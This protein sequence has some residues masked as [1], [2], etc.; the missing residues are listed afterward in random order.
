MAKGKSKPRSGKW[1]TAFKAA[2]AL[3]GTAVIGY[4]AKKMFAPKPG[5]GAGVVVGGAGFVLATVLGLF[6]GTRKYVPLAL[7][8]SVGLGVLEGF[9][10]SIDKAS[11]WVADLL[12]G[13]GGG[14]TKTTASGGGAGSKSS[15]GQGGAGPS[16]QQSSGGQSIA[17][18][19]VNQTPKQAKPDKVS[20][21]LQ[22][23]ESLAN[24]GSN[25]AGALRG[26]GVPAGSVGIDDFSDIQGANGIDDFSSL[27]GAGNSMDDIDAIADAIA[28]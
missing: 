5:L 17:Y 16:S 20:Q 2:I 22:F 14:M 23:G 25:I 4:G 6:K 7:G 24:L 1:G 13:K 12:T 9:D 10:T 21:Y 27:T 28:R 18:T 15:G 26:G 19:P 8:A 11:N 3:A